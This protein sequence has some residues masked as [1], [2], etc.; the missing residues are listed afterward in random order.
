MKPTQPSVG[1][2]NMSDIIVFMKYA[3]YIK[4]LG[5]RETWEEIV[6]RNK[7]MH[8]KQYPQLKKELEWAYEFV[9]SKKL[10][11]SMRSLQFG[12]KPV[13]LNPAR[14]YNCAYLAMNAIDAFKEVMFLLLAGCGVG[15][16]VQQHHI[17]QLPIVIKPTKERRFLVAD[18]IEGWADA[19]GALISAYMGERK[20]LPRFDYS[21]IRAKGTPLKTSGGVAPGPEPLKTCLHQVQTILDRK[22]TGA[23]LTSLEIHDIN[24]H[25]A[26]AV[27]SG[28]IRRAALIAFF[29]FR[30]ELMRTCKFGDWSK[31]DPQRGRANNSAVILR[32]KITEEEFQRYWEVIRASGCGEPGIFF[33][34][35]AE[36]L[37]N[38]CVEIALLNMLFCNLATINDSNIVSQEDFNDRARAAG[39]I[40]TCQAGYTDFHYLREEWKIN[41]EKHALIG[42]SRTGI[43]SLVTGDLNEKEAADC[44]TQANA[45]V[46]EKIGINPAARCTCIKPEGTSSL[47]LGVSSGIHAWFDKYYLRR[48]Q[49]NKQE[50]IYKYLLQHHPTLLEDDFFKPATDAHICV[51]MKAPENAVV[52]VETA[53]QFLERVLRQHRRW[54]K[55]GHRVGDNHN[56]VSCTVYIKEHEWERVGK[57]MWENREH[58]NGI[59]VMPVSTKVYKNL[60]HETITE[61]EHNKRVKELTLVDLTQVKEDGDYTNR[62]GE[63]SCAAG[64]CE[65]V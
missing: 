18:S 22:E 44:V 38:P 9:Y 3:K 47:V 31:G 21:D 37:A 52:G 13:E 2:Q 20:A 58:Y 36:M 10:L 5:R 25:L 51:P 39:I 26:D 4:R 24:C 45:E 28:G 12:G 54:I 60:P 53:L 50:S 19:V 41:C 63:L 62:Q 6:T 23:K 17:N 49:V 59:S 43:A 16:S 40:A 57:W 30:D 14:S 61:E 33:T 48:V 32:H 11:P 42:V 7:N 55:P 35:N 29:S 27:L 8:L 15:Y 56:N 46:A 34:N 64:A 65:T 1:V